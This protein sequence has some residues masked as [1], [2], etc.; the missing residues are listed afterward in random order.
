MKDG[1]R[2]Q[3]YQVCGARLSGRAEVLDRGRQG[4]QQA[5]SKLSC[6]LAAMG[7]KGVSRPLKAPRVL[8]YRSPAE[9]LAEDASGRA[10]VAAIPDHFSEDHYRFEACAAKIV[11][12][13]LQNIA[14]IDITRR[15]RDGGRDA[16]GEIPHRNGTVR[17]ARRFRA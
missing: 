5:F 11:E 16:V 1:K 8:E 3:N 4:E 15:V 14:S 9:Q 7:G 13:M 12:V 6:G 17:G 10:I 2:F